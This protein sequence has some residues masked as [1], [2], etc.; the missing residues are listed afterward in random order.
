ML[1]KTILEEKNIFVVLFIYAFLLIFFCSL[2]SPLYPFNDWSDINLYFNIGK[3]M[4]HGQTLYTDIFDHK[5][6]LIFVI[7]GIGSLISEQSFLGM[8]IIESLT[9][10]LMIFSTYLIAR[11][12]LDKIYAFAVALIFPVLLLS[13]SSEGGSAEEFIVLFEIISLYLFIR[14]FKNKEASAH[15]PAHMLLHGIMC[16]VVIFIKINLVVFWVFPLLAIFIN[17]L[18]KKEYKNLFWNIFS[19]IGGV[20][21]VSLPIVIYFW[22]N[23]ALSYAWDTYI[24]LNRTYAQIGDFSRIMENLIVRFYQRLKYD[25]YEFVIILIGAVYFPFKYI[26]CRIGKAAIILS[27]ASLY[28]VIFMAANYVFYYSMPYYIFS[29]LGCIVILDLVRKYIRIQP[30]WYFYLLFTIVALACGIKTKEFF[31]R[32]KEV[33]LRQK[34]PNDVLHKFY[35]IVIQEKNPTLM[36]LGLDATTGIFTMANIMPNVKYF[37]SPNLPYNIYPEMRDEQTRYIEDK[38]VEF[39]ILS[40]ASFSY[41]YY[42]ALPIL[43]EN[44]NLESTFEENGISTYFLYKRK[45]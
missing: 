22:V 12:Y 25:N 6:P 14:Y 9:W 24:T 20:L 3:A 11:L 45:K 33:I 36:C 44:Y 13:H 23:N 1:K 40:G 41:D 30:H 43:Q 15:K 2:M 42:R 31:S 21:I 16:T 32:S 26:G 27:F 38:E 35:N 37:I 5:G 4:F 28:T 19:F 34:Q 29:I 39:I 17:I 18:L 8:Y 10:V 7:Y